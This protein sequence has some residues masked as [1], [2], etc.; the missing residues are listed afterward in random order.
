[1]KKISIWAASLAVAGLAFGQPAP[2]SAALLT[3][4]GA[5]VETAMIPADTGGI[6][7]A[8]GSEWYGDRFYG[9]R[10][11]WTYRHHPGKVRVF[12]SRYVRG[13]GYF[14]CYSGKFGFRNRVPVTSGI[15]RY[16]GCRSACSYPSPYWPPEVGFGVVV[17]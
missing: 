2:S 13:C 7:V 3:S 6:M 12:K 9:Q 17:H 4:P 5:P 15:V 8:S 11:W 10:W 14:N 1:M 16:R